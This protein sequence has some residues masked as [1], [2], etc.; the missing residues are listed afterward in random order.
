M[1][2]FYETVAKGEMERKNRG[3]NG[4][5]FQKKHKQ[6]LTCVVKCGIL[7]KSAFR[8]KWGLPAARNGTSDTQK[9]ITIYKYI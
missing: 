8:E 4:T 7:Y 9:I 3:E 2:V 6:G 5:Q 1:W